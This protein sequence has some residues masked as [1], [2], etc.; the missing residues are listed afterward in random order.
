MCIRMYIVLP[1]SLLQEI[2]KNWKDRCFKDHHKIDG[3]DC[4]ILSYLQEVYVTRHAP[5]LL[6]SDNLHHLEEALI[7]VFSM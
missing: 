1:C 4:S 3:T 5:F 2:K 6:H 7:S